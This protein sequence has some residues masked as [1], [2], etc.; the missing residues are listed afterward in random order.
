PSGKTFVIPY[1]MNDPG[2]TT[3][4]YG[5]G[6]GGDYCL[7]KLDG[8]LTVNGTLLVSALQNQITGATGGNP[9]HLIV[10]S[11]KTITVSGS[12]YAYGP[13]TGDGKIETTSTAKIHETIEFSDNT[14][15]IYVYNIYNE[16]SSKKVFPF[17][18]MF[19]NSIEVP[20][21]YQLGAT[22]TGHV[23][24][25]YDDVCPAEVPLIAGSGAMMNH[26]AGTITK[27]YDHAKGQFVFCFNEGSVVN[28]GSFSITVNATIAGVSKTI[29]MKSSDYYI[30]L[31]TPFRFEVAGNLT[32]NDKYKALPGMTID[33]KEGGTLTIAE[34]AELVLYRRNDF[35]YRGKHANSTEQWGYTE[36]AYPQNPQRFNGVS[37][38][39]SFNNSNMGSAKLNVDGSLIVNGGLYVTDEEQTDT[40]NG[41]TLT[42]DGYNYL[43]GTGT[44]NMTNAKTSLTSINEVMRAAGPNDLAWDTVAVVPL[45]GLKGDATADEPEQYMSLSGKAVRGWTNE[46]GL[47]VWVFKIYAT[48]ITVEDSLDLYFYIKTSDIGALEGSK[49]TARITKVF[50]DGREDVSDTVPFADWELDGNLYGFGFSDIS[51]KEMT[52]GITAVVCYDGKPI[53][54]FYTETIEAYALRTLKQDSV[55]NAEYDS[56]NALMRTALVDLLNYGAACQTHF[57]YGTDDLA[58]ADLTDAQ[59][60]YATAGDVSMVSE[61]VKGKYLYAVSVSATNTLVYSVY[62]DFGTDVLPD[63]V[64]ATVTYEDHYGNEKTKTYEQA[65]WVEVPYGEKI[66]YGINVTG[67]PMASGR[68]EITCTVNV[69]GE[70][71]VTKDSV[72]GYAARSNLTDTMQMMMRFV[73][74]AKAYFTK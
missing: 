23:A 67:V 35:D 71:S 47:N 65:D 29:T 30:P 74:S 55:V 63:G 21:T 43:T 62:Y 48:N 36:K 73:D 70:S 60:D 64:T 18:T 49:L 66:L 40:T 54:E 59:K 33:V 57:K 38:P 19:V 2:N 31:S 4:A 44:I 11:G 32:I 68:S 28:T 34:E 17:N 53:S 1:G 25:R 56:K 27:Y 45:K 50:A 72:E 14:V 52:D 12:L 61:L 46:A 24:I 51:A 10:A 69:N 39:F 20:V 16:R 42:D 9:G 3:P 37:Y 41:I 15:V 6:M 5:G 26:T 13:V 7:V 22:L 8:N 58:T